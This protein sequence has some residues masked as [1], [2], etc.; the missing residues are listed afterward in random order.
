[1]KKSLAFI[2]LSL[3]LLSATCSKKNSD[4]PGGP[5][6]PNV[7]LPNSGFLVC[8]GINSQGHHDTLTFYFQASGNEMSPY[9]HQFLENDNEIR[10]DNN[11]DNTVNIRRKKPYEQNGHGFDMFGIQENKSPSGSIFPDHPYLWTMFQKD[12]SILNH[13]IVKRNDSD[14]TKFTI[15]SKAFPGYYLGVA[16]WKNATY[17]TTSRFVFTTKPV[18][19]WFIQK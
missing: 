8:M 15:E 10:F 3:F 1:M 6:G 5:G 17:P 9:T 4:V 12:E 13:F 11:S 2:A 18:E 7:L 19:F 14:K 16:K